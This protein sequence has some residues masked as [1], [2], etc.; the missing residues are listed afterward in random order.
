MENARIAKEDVVQVT[1]LQLLQYGFNMNF[2][3]LRMGY[4]LHGGSLQYI[5][6]HIFFTKHMACTSLERKAFNLL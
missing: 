5:I 1:L 3:V 4:G 6:I 2:L